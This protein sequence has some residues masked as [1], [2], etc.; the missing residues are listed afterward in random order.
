MS[1]WPNGARMAAAITF[2]MDA[3]S[4]IHISTKDGWRRP[5][6]ISMG[7]YGPN[8]AIPRII[9]TY[10]RL[11]LRQSF[12]IPGWCVQTY[13]EAV[14]ALL[15][16]G[17]EVGCHGWLHQNPLDQNP[18]EQE[19]DLDRSLEA[20]ERVAGHKPVGYRAPVYQITNELP[21]LLLDRGFKYESS[22]MADDDPYLLDVSG[23][24]LAE[25]PPHW[26]VD[27]WPPFAHYEEIGYMMPVRGPRE[28]LAP[29]FE[30]FDAARTAGGLWH[31]V[32]HPFLTGRRA[33]WQVVEQWLERVVASG[34]VWFATLSDLA[35][36]TLARHRD[37]QAVRVETF[38]YYD[39]SQR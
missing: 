34:D 12:F 9:E 21:D 19:R 29:F 26:G 2:D 30:E 14:N 27:D 13:P 18:A 6:P 24:L 31:A 25:I 15:E 22:M 8:V 36:H 32:W 39:T 33:R 1:H 7:R 4:L 38:P 23:R 35:E 17:H 3:D 5:Y 28:G 20:F 16:A 37:G 11:G 10:R